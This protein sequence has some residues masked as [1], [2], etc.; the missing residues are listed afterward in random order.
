MK[1]RVMIIGVSRGGSTYTRQMIQLY[2]GMGPHQGDGNVFNEPIHP[3]NVI[4]SEL[5][6]AQFYAGVA[7]DIRSES[8]CVVKDHIQH[9]KNYKHVTGDKFPFSEWYEGFYKIK[10]TRTNLKQMVFSACIARARNEWFN[11]SDHQPIKIDIELFKRQLDNYT[12]A[13]T[14]I[15]LFDEPVDLVIDYDDFEGDGVIHDQLLMSD[16]F[17]EPR[18]LPMTLKKR[19]PAGDLVL[20][21]DELIPIY[22]S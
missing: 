8:P 19:P 18:E 10:L 5:E 14:D 20:N 12:R 3:Q 21:M 13:I 7:R 6:P 16:I 4:D 17:T 15:L 11:L 1:D 2:M 9:Y 22:I